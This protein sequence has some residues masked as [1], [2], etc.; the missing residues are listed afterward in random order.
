MGDS[1]VFSM[2]EDSICYRRMPIARDVA[3]IRGPRF[4]DGARQAVERTTNVSI[5]NRRVIQGEEVNHFEDTEG[6]DRDR[7]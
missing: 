6:T 3:K 2:L 4:H 1:I 7:G 5:G